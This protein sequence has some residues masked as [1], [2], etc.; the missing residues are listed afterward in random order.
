MDEVGPKKIICHG[1]NLWTYDRAYKRFSKIMHRK[2]LPKLFLMHAPEAAHATSH[3]NQ[4]CQQNGKQVR[5]ADIMDVNAADTAR[6][7]RA[8]GAER[9]IH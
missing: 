7:V 2:R 9:L 4:A 6:Q 8:F 3:Q 1:D 5:P